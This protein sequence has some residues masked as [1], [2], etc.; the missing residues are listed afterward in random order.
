[1]VLLQVDIPETIGHILH[2]KHHSIMKAIRSNSCK[3]YFRLEEECVPAF[4]AEEY[5]FSNAA[6]Q[7]QLF[8]CSI[9]PNE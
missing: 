8:L 7:S 6:G 1:M 5:N 2:G 9:S 3:L 4:Y